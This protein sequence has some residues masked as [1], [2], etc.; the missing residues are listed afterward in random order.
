MSKSMSE[1][2]SAGRQGETTRRP[3]ST[4]RDAQVSV[5]ILA[6]FATFIGPKL[7]PLFERF[8]Q[9]SDMFVSMAR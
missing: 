4:R 5:F 1:D 8:Y 7:N 9:P 6:D 2:I 3:Q